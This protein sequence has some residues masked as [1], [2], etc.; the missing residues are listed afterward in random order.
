MSI[1]SFGV[2]SPT[3]TTRPKSIIGVR[4]Y[5]RINQRR[6]VNP[7][8][9]KLQ[10]IRDNTANVA[11]RVTVK[12][13]LPQNQNRRPYLNQKKILTHSYDGQLK[14]VIKRVGIENWQIIDPDIKKI[15]FREFIEILNL[16][17]LPRKAATVRAV[18]II[19]KGI[20]NPSNFDSTNNLCVDDILYQICLYLKLIEYDPEILPIITE[21]LADIVTSGSCSQGRCTRL[22]QVYLA[23]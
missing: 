2:R 21:Q 12:K 16:L 17:S 11:N 19:I 5:N 18:N 8:T 3:G 22:F 7:N 15:E 14:E 13:V 10:I 9:V 1:H 23:L 20:G 4:N 6:Y